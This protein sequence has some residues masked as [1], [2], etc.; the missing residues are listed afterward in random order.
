M[1][2]FERLAALDIPNV[3]ARPLACSDRAVVVELVAQEHA[4]RSGQ[5]TT[6]GVHGDWGEVLERRL[7]AATTVDALAK[8]HGDPDLIKIDVEGH[9][10]RVIQGATRTLERARPGLFVEVHN[11][12]LGE[13][14]AALLGPLYPNMRRVDHPHYRP[15]EWGALN[16]FWLLAPTSHQGQ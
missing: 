6:A 15:G 13:Q 5:L 14:L 11:A 2:S 10:L 4:I 7:V 12:E 8:Q 1:E 3:T 16:H 9:E